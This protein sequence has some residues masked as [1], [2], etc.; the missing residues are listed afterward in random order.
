MPPIMTNRPPWSHGYFRILG[1][2]PL[3]DE[4]LARHCFR[5]SRGRYLDERQHEMPGPVEPCGDRA[6]FSFRGID[7]RVSDAIGIPRAPD[8]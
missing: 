2:L 4:V 6:L 1:N 3:R 5:D 7:R 8:T